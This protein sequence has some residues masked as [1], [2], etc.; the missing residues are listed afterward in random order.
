MSNGRS[1]RRNLSEQQQVAQPE[2]GPETPEMAPDEPQVN[3]GQALDPN[4]AQ[5][6]PPEKKRQLDMVNST[7]TDMLYHPEGKEAIQNMLQ[8]SPP[9][10]AIPTAVNTIFTKFEDMAKQ[11]KGPVPLDIKLA[12]GVHLFSEVMELAEAAGVI[13][14]DIPEEAMQSLLR[15]SMQMY[16]QR[17]LKD[18]S[19]DPIELQ[20]QVEP[21]LSGEE[22]EI[23]MHF[24]ASM[25][26]EEKLTPQ[27]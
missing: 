7:L 17:G 10:Q 12:S 23:G 19:I 15:D 26:T 13:A 4:Q 25:G 1:I 21:M 22:K 20:Q 9:E 2:M 18:K 11:K 5:D 6:L 24:A 8:E 16:I 3:T 14:E 27:Q